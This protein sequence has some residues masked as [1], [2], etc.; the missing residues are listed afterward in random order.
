[1]TE[2]NRALWNA[3]ADLHIGSRFYDVDGFLSGGSSLREIEIG[4]VGEVR[5]KTLLHL[6]CHFGLDTL[7]WAR[8]GARVTGVDF[9]DRAIAHA[10][11]LA[12]RAGLD[13]R[14]VCASVYDA[15]AALDGERFDIVFTSYGALPW[16]PELTRWSEA[17]ARVVAPGGVVHVIEFHPF[18]DMLDG[19]GERLVHPYFNL[20]P[21]R[22]TTAASYT[23]DATAAAWEEVTWSHALGDVV[24]A[25]IAAGLRI[26]RLNEYDY[27]PYGLWPFTEEVEPGRWMVRGRPREF[28]L[29]YAVKASAA[30]R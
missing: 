9:S 29:V 6:Q 16:L 28:P 4:E 7:S 1:M 22:T 21:I 13:A 17:V 11:E 25:L 5:G 18:L 20:G 24:N 3:W 19:G 12:E 23:G 8:L 15:G 30:S 2:T 26:E 14:F 27:S 10:R